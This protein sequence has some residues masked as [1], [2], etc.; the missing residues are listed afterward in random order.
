MAT[1]LYPTNDAAAVTPASWVAAWD[2]DGTTTVACQSTMLASGGFSPA[3]RSGSG[4]SGQKSAAVR[5]VSPAINA[6]TIEGTFKGVV[7]CRETNATDNYFIAVAIKV[8][9]S[10]GS[11][12]GVL[13]EPTSST[14]TAEIPSG[15][16]AMGRVLRDAS[17]NTNITLTPV[18]CSLNDRIVIEI[19]FHQV[20]TSVAAFDIDVPTTL[21]QPQ[22]YRDAGVVANE[23]HWFQFSQDISGLTNT[24][25]LTWIITLATP[26]DAVAATG[27][28]NPT[29]ISGLSGTPTYMTAGDLV[30]MIGHE[31][32]TGS[33]LAV[34]AAGGQT[35]NTLAAINTTLVT[36]RM[37]WCVYNGTWSADPS[38][39]FGGTTCNSVQL[40][41]F[42]GAPT[43]TTWTVNQAQVEL[44]TAGSPASI[45]GQTTTGTNPTLTLAGWFTAD[46]NTWGSISGT[47]WVNLG[48]EQYRNTSGSDQSSTYAWKTQTAA[49]AT[50]NVTKTQTANGPDAGTTFII[51]FAAA[52][53]VPASLVYNTSRNFINIQ[54]VR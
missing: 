10:G 52:E 48:T 42:R 12:R 35:W 50:G 43:F 41:V 51:T 17:D 38:V 39:D 9:D 46:D 20:S 27:T 14:A 44:D 23:S 7:N 29:A 22:Q 5:Y 8:I 34:S 11:Q 25:D 15:G 4:V 40:H 36:A 37:F 16:S 32:A 3:P 24:A 13:L 6:Q 18:A 2:V 54:L 31:R 30:C 45:T 28:A 33:T 21:N 47:G 49:G 53:P 26:A 19:G 1:R